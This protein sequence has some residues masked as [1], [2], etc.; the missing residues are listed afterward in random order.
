MSLS[1]NARHTAWQELLACLTMCA[2]TRGGHSE[3]H[4]DSTALPAPAPPGGHRSD[5]HLHTPLWALPLKA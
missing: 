3:A 2:R 4:P 5:A 1:C